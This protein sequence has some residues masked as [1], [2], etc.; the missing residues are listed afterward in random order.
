MQQAGCKIGPPDRGEGTRTLVRKTEIDPLADAFRVMYRRQMYESTGNGIY[1]A[2]AWKIIRKHKISIP[3]WI[4]VAVDEAAER[5]YFFQEKGSGKGRRGDRHREYG[6]RADIQKIVRA[7]ELYAEN[8]S[9]SQEKLA[10]E[11]GI[12]PG[13]FSKLLDK[14]ELPGEPYPWRSIDRKGVT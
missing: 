10:H 8:P 4:L 6:D 2:Q 14:W 7:C 5:G 11:L 9:W 13:Q 12:D 3:D 1:A